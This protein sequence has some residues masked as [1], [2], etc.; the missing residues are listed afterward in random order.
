MKQPRHFVLIPAAGVGSRMGSEI[1][2]Q[3]LPIAGQPMLRRTADVFRTMP[4]VA[5]V[6]VI[7]SPGDAWAE[8]VFAHDAAGVTLLRCGG[9]TRRDSVLNGLCAMETQIDANDWVLVHDAARPGIT[10]EL[11]N[12]LIA[13]TSA[14]PVG[15]LLGMPVADTVKRLDEGKLVTVSR[16]NLW[17]AQ[18]PQMFRYAALRQA[19]LQTPSATDEAGAI[20]AMGQTPM[21]VEGHV[22]NT[23]IT[24]P[25]DRELVEK[26]LV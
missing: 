18:T 7:I 21:L 20:E 19:L 3:Y 8:D 25:A 4:V 5:G 2:K 15:G 9:E 17:L 11:V 16:A 24:R 14:H 6:F 10:P 12:K 26:F 23:K 1:P 13:E 22:R